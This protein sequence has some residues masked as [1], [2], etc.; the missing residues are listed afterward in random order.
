MVHLSVIPVWGH[1]D[2]LETI[3]QAV[4]Q[5][6]SEDACQSTTGWDL[7]LHQL[8][9]W[10]LADH[11]KVPQC[12]IAETWIISSSTANSIVKRFRIWG[13]VCEQRTR[14]KI[15]IWWLQ[16]LQNRH[17]AEM[18]RCLRTQFAVSSVKVKALLCKE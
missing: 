8:H 16:V 1:G 18:S 6:A 13:N 4:H 12:K 5:V 10:C 11:N 14:L 7:N 2:L 9:M 15:N 3:R 17:D